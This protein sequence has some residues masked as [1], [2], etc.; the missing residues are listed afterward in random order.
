VVD[1]PE[2]ERRRGV[3]SAEVGLQVLAA[4]G[5]APGAVGLNGL[6]GGLGLAPAKVHRYLVSLI[7]AGMA[8]QRP[9]GRYDLGFEAARLGMAAVA[10]V[11]VVNRAADALPGLV[12]Q[13]GCTAMLS[14][15]GPAGATVVRWEKSSP[16]L[17]TALG[18]GAVL[19]LTTSATGLAF[20]GWLPARLL[21]ER[22]AAEMPGLDT[23]SLAARQG[24]IR[25]GWVTRAH[26]SFIP[27]LH[28]LAVPVLDLG[29]RAE[30]VVTLVATRA[31]ALAPGAAGHRALMGFGRWGRSAQEG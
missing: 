29:G 8:V 30:A 22:L 13:T 11:D 18:V 14:V 16:Q 26:G 31:E 9:D 19:P 7:A 6:A 1:D 28:A 12:A 3:Q 4:L 17:I 2:Q 23:E 24:E 21:A 27:G 5:R 10:R 20:L 25:R 15:W